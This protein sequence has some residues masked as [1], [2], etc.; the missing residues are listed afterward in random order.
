MMT[1]TKV[2][3]EMALFGPT[4]QVATPKVEAKKIAT[5]IA[6]RE[7]KKPFAQTEPSA[8]TNVIAIWEIIERIAASPNA[9]PDALDKLLSMQERIMDRQAKLAFNEAFVV[10]AP[11]LPMITKDGRII[12]KEK[13]A[14][15]RRDG[16][17]TQDTPYAT[18][19]AISPVIVPVLSSHG[20]SIR[21]ETANAP[22]GKIR[23]TSI[24]YGHGHEERSY[25]DFELDSTGS[26]NNA[27][28]RHSAITY[29][30]RITACAQINIVTKGEDDSGKSAGRA[31]VAGDPLTPEELEKVVDFA[32][33]C[34][35]GE[36]TLV[37]HLNKTKPAGH[38]DIKKIA[39]LPRSRFD[40]TILALQ[41]YDA[42]RR[43]READAKGKTDAG[44]A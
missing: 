16:E 13:T 42:N 33:A 7:A 18:W 39:D 1:K 32:L 10:M 30:R 8:P 28:A 15:G 36:P 3:E 29:G 43:Q 40:E 19:E 44:G 6:K 41:G 23:I 27:Q 37:K 2:K 11:T 34:Q 17:T 14:S 5:A 20:F 12:V 25:L 35:C 24:L 21:H 22:D 31:I 9:N 4:D 26:K 38:P